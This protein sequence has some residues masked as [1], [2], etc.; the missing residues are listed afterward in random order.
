MEKSHT[1]QAPPI[2]FAIHSF[3]CLH[4]F[5]QL[6]FAK[7][8]G[9]FSWCVSLLGAI[10]FLVLSCKWLQDSRVLFT[11]FAYSASVHQGWLACV[12]ASPCPFLGACF[13]VRWHRIVP[14][15]LTL[16]HTQLLHSQLAHWLCH[17]RC[18]T[19]HQWFPNCEPGLPGR[20]AETS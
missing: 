18:H 12:G 13:R 19:R 17:L 10:N 16:V 5:Q 7:R 1:P 14:Q 3:L 11:A 6:L 9:N 2:I 4:V 20:A 8:V 15:S